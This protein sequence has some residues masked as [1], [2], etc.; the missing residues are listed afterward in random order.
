VTRLKGDMPER[1]DENA[2]YKKQQCP[3]DDPITPGL[4]C[5]VPQGV[6]L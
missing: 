4:T 2:D 3:Q 1:E 5:S 6:C